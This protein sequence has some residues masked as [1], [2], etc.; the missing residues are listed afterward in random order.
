MAGELPMIRSKVGAG[1]ALH[2][3]TH[4]AQRDVV[5]DQPASVY[6]LGHGAKIAV[7][8]MSPAVGRTG[9]EERLQLASV[10][11]EI[12]DLGDGEARVLRLLA[13][14][15]QDREALSLLAKIK[16]IRGELSA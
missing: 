13:D 15:P 12:G 7:D 4:L 14:Q 1:H 3:T 2:E 10:L 5:V 9:L 8:V 16:H 11:V 6:H